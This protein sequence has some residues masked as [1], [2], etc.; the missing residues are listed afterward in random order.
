MKHLLYRIVA[1]TLSILFL[2]S[3]ITPI[4]SAQ[5]IP[6]DDQSSIYDNTVWYKASGSGVGSSGF[7]G[8]TVGGTIGS[9]TL[10]QFLQALAYHE[11]GG[12]PTAGS[13]SGSDASGK[14]QYLASTWQA[15]ASAYYPPATKYSIAR[16][17]PESYQ[18][19]V[20]YIE[21]TVKS[22]KYN[23]DVAEMAV[24]HIYPSVADNPS[25]WPT[26]K[27]GNNPTAQQYADDVIKILTSGQA[28][29]IPMKEKQAPQFGQYL[30]KAGKPA[31]LNVAG[32]GSCSCQQAIISTA[33][34]F[35]WPTYHAPVYLN[36]T[37]A[38]ESAI[39]AALSGGEYVGPTTEPYLGVDC[40]AFVTRVMRDSKADPNYNSSNCNTT[41]QEAYMEQHPDKYQRLGPQASTA[42]LQPGDIA[43]NDVHTFLYLGDQGFPGYDAVSASFSSNGL[44]WRA[45]MA[46][47][48]YF[49][50]GSPFN[51]F[52]LK[53]PTK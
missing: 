46:S 6:Q 3:I 16:D 53:C 37:A 9:I 48:A 23:G 19:A 39:T 5:S 22:I 38:Y 26:Y 36:K 24:S 21:Y 50:E 20:A 42:N 17:A 14:Y 15:S 13:P 1:V 40:G 8:C 31:A 12:D 29:S 11:S 2:F 52:R 25:V 47:T 51:W 33:K 34:S 18:D 35:A 7:S 27:I 28:S 43:I 10:D 4:A 49:Q 44:S 30:A 41:C 45:P 32:G